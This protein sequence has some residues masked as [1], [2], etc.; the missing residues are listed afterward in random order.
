MTKEVW[1]KITF[2]L[3]DDKVRAMLKDFKIPTT[4][5][6][7]EELMDYMQEDFEADLELV[8]ENCASRLADDLG[9]EPPDD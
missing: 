9:I 2:E 7:I 6:H 5:D 8:L 3:E 4:E 1:H